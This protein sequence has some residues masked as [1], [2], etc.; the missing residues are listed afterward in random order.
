[1]VIIGMQGPFGLVATGASHLRELD[2]LLRA[3]VMI[4]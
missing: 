1:M 4:R 3:S 2:I